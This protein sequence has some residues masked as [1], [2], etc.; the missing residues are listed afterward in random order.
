MTDILKKFEMLKADVNISWGNASPAI[1]EAGSA[2]LEHLE[3]LLD[4]ILEAYPIDREMTLDNYLEVTRTVLVSE[5]L[6]REL[7]G[8][9]GRIVEDDSDRKSW[10]IVDP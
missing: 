9:T 8:E 3:E 1:D 10:V 5:E 4:I 6:L 2:A 7:L